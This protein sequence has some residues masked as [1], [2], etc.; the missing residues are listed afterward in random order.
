[1]VQKTEPWR[2]KAMKD[3]GMRERDVV[4]VVCDEVVRSKK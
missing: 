1:M 2:K 3:R 4:K